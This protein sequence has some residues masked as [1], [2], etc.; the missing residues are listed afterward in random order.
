[1]RVLDLTNASAELLDRV[2]DVLVR[3]HA[4]VSTDEP[5]RTR[6]DTEAF[7][8][9]VPNV[10][11]REYWIAESGGDC[12][13][14]AQLGVM[15]GSGSV[16]ILV[17]P[18]ARR[19]GHG[20]AFLETVL[21]QATLRAARRLVGRHATEAGAHF[22][23]RAGA[24]DEHR[25][26][27]SVLRLPL[28]EHLRIR[29][30]DGYAVSG[31]IGAAPASLLDSYVRARPAVND[32][33]GEDEVWSA[34]RVR[35]LEATVE[36]RNRDMRLT[37]ALDDHGDVV[38]FTELRVSRTPGAAAGTDDTAV[39]AEHR[40]RGLARWIKLESLLGL[41]K[42]RPDVRLVTTANAEENVAMLGL[43]RSLGFEPVAVYT[44]CALQ[45]PG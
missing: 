32:A 6:A 13:G 20:T 28:A 24:V 4:E 33:P 40:R 23:A 1:V 19:A 26:V 2:Y 11:T 17:R 3:C 8:R 15:E 39:V 36:R 38:G 16:E 25:E 44:N 12:V 35:D 27:H 29:P 34:A 45:L 9:H 5:Y 30:I 18:D 31:W 37:V 21:E 43:N 7:L 42:D 22:A 10:E 41:Q 14:F